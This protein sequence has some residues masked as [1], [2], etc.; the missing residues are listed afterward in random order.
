MA[1][2]KRERISTETL[3]RN[4]FQTLVACFFKIPLGIQEKVSLWE[5]VVLCQ[6]MQ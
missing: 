3:V 5:E 1:H 6:A 4:C 2:K